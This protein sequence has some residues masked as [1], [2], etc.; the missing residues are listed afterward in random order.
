SKCSNPSGY[1]VSPNSDSAC[2][3]VC[4][5]VSSCANTGP[6]G[7]IAP[8]PAKAGAT[9]DDAVARKTERRLN[10]MQLL[11]RNCSHNTVA[12]DY[13]AFSVP[14]QR[15]IT[16]LKFP[17]A[18]AAMAFRNNRRKDAQLRLFFPLFLGRF[19][20]RGRWLTFGCLGQRHRVVGQGVQIINEV[21]ALLR[22]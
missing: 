6:H 15:S 9:T 4:A 7:N 22:P 1:L 20:T 11:R 19:G 18:R 8:I 5:C 10:F 21:C 3:Q 17:R 14:R 2:F 12:E 13:V 16:S